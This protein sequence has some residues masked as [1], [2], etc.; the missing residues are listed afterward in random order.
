MTS[1]DNS[2]QPDFHEQPEPPVR[3]PVFNLPGVIVLVIAV[4][5]GIEALRSYVISHEVDTWLL[6]QA[7]FI[8]A[9]YNGPVDGSWFW[10][11]VTYS[12][13]HGG[14][15]TRQSGRRT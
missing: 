1:P 3:E 5:A 15:R 9:R 2:P 8:P 4:M 12:L 13:L 14:W 7:A 11:P 6:L 10:S